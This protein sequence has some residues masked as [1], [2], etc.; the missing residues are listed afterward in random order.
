MAGVNLCRE[1]H[2]L[3][4]LL[5]AL[6]PSWRFFDWIAPS[7]R[8]E[9]RLPSGTHEE[10]LSWRAFRP[11]PVRLR[12]HMM[13]RRLVWNPRWNESLFL[14]SCAE[15]LMQN[16]NE[17]SL[18]QIRRRIEADI[19]KEA[20]V[21]APAMGMQFRLVFISRSGVE[22]VETETFVSPVYPLAAQGGI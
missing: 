8:I 7:P 2:M 9:F 6:I 4:L 14:V 5:P 20:A 19:R 11:R 3:K 15:R 13:L 12:P 16:P 22:L 18:D 1:L 21:S 17:H 10:P